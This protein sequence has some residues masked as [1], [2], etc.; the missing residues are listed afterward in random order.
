MSLQKAISSIEDELGSGEGMGDVRDGGIGGAPK[1]K[2]E[3]GE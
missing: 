1:G 3:R 2:G